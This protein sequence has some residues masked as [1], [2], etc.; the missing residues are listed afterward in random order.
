MS[1]DWRQGL[2]PAE[3]WLPEDTRERLGALGAADLLV[4]IATHNDAGTVAGLIEAVTAG[5][6]KAYPDARAVLVN[7]DGGSQDDTPRLVEEAAGPHV[8]VLRVRHTPSSLQSRVLPYHGVPGRERAWRTVFAVAAALG[9]RACLVVDGDLRSLTPDW[10][11]ALLR[12]VLEEHLDLIVPLYR[13]HKYEGS[14]TASLLYPLTRALYGQRVR[15]AVGGAFGLSGRFLRAALAKDLWEQDVARAGL[16]LWLT[17]M[18][19][20]EGFALGHVPLGA[21]VHAAK[22][23]EPDLSAT[24]V[25]VVGTVFR[26]MED[27]EAV[28]PGIGGSAP[29]PCFGAA[30]EVSREAP[31]VNVGRLVG[32][33]QQGLRDLLPV[34]EIILAA[35][36][37]AALLTL[38]GLE[39]DEFRFP[40]D[41]WGQVVYDFALA[42]HHRALHRE[43]LLKSLTPLYLGWTA[44]LILETEAYG[45]A[46]IEPRLE[47]LCLRFE[48][49]KPYLIERWR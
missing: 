46:A 23:A 38:G 22:G 17:T 39:P 32:A 16:D 2:A 44:S 18:A 14:L 8:P 31:P 25:Q 24:V 13:R 6:A 45:V 27:Y 21:K 15:P 43:H 9:A 20:A 4:G 34:W 1:A 33:F 36:T 11:G 5:L 7:S 26:L 41:L 48:A 30:P 35:D 37:L 47:A 12:P 49:L 29:V 10:I 40:I 19:A 28:W 42:A 3:D